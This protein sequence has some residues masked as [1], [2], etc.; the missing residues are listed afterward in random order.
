MLKVYSVCFYHL[1]NPPIG[2]GPMGPLSR[3]TGA[4]GSIPKTCPDGGC[5]AATGRGYE[6]SPGLELLTPGGVAVAAMLFTLKKL[7]GGPGGCTDAGGPGVCI[8][9]GGP[10]GCIDDGGPGDCMDDGGPGYCNV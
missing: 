3:D 5:P 8:E 4:V 10:G 9:D 7:G 1:V 6:D 2:G